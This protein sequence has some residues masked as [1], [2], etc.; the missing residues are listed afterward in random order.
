MGHRGKN[1]SFGSFWCKSLWHAGIV[2]GSNS[3]FQINCVLRYA[4]YNINPR[5]CDDKEETRTGFQCIWNWKLF[6]VGQFNHLTSH[7]V[8]RQILVTEKFNVLFVLL[9]SYFWMVFGFMQLKLDNKRERSLITNQTIINDW[10]T[11]KV[12][13]ATLETIKY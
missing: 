8:C 10:G 3:I 11:E 12:V 1:Y 5:K 2:K 13:L 9:I 4:S 7:H 6:V